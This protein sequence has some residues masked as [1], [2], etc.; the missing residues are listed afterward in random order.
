MRTGNQTSF[1]KGHVPHNTKKVGSRKVKRG[2]WYVKTDEGWQ[3][4]HRLLWIK[5]EKS[6]PAG[7][8]VGFKDGNRSN[9]AIDNL[10]LSTRR[11]NMKQNSNNHYPSELLTAF[12]RIKKLE[13]HIKNAKK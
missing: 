10:Y 1:K 6:I 9:I 11:V 3:L 8:I 2:Y 7:G 13:K 4:E 12:K 5:H